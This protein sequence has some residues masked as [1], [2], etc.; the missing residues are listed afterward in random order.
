MNMS[1]TGVLF[2][3]E[4]RLPVGRRI[5]LMISWPVTLDGRLPLIVAAVGKITRSDAKT[6]AVKLEHHEFRVRG[7]GD[8]AVPR[9]SPQS[10]L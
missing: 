8:L 4:G 6:A 5:E 10:Q 2:R 1:S 9:K 3:A 7:S